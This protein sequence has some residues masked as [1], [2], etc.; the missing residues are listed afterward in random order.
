M[1]T[2]TAAPPP[3]TDNI[4]DD[5]IHRPVLTVPLTLPPA[6]PPTRS[7]EPTSDLESVLPSGSMNE[8]NIINSEEQV[9]ADSGS[10]SQSQ[11]EL[12]E[13]VEEYS[14]CNY[15]ESNM[16]DEESLNIF[17]S[18]KGVVNSQI[19]DK[20]SKVVCTKKTTQHPQ[21]ILLF[22]GSPTLLPK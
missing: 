5:L 14:D 8:N 19:T 12:K 9:L 18:K 6:D 22:L 10:V 15:L 1:A 13:I 21:Q 2:T 7:G 4:M 16:S 20:Y 11:E 3:P 17:L